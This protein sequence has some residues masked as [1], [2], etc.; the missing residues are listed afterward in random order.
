MRKAQSR[1]LQY[2]C[3][4]TREQPKCRLVN[5]PIAF[6]SRTAV[7]AYLQGLDAMLFKLQKCE[8]LI[9]KCSFSFETTFL[10]LSADFY[11]FIWKYKNLTFT[12]D[13]CVKITNTVCVVHA[14]LK[15]MI[16]TFC[17]HRHLIQVFQL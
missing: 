4:Q 9:Q 1:F 12:P 11:F 17:M 13:I 8:T 7:F 16:Y 2:I 15:L 14:V 6:N 5:M 10:L 3:I